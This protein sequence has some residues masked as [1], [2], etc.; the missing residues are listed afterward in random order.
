M[1]SLT[2]DEFE[3]VIARERARGVPGAVLA[4]PVAERLLSDQLT[5][6]L[7]YRR[8]VSADERTAPSFLL[9]SVEGGERQGRHSVLGAQP[10]LE[11]LASGTRVTVTDRRTG[12]APVQTV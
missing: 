6:V 1:P 10:A 12:A 7:A 11:V 2:A 8:L 4:V 9:E 5:P 3:S